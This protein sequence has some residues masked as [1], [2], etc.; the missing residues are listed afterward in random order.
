MPA[1]RLG[2]CYRSNS[3]SGRPWD[4]GRPG[5]ARLPS[6]QSR[7]RPRDGDGKAGVAGDAH[8]LLDVGRLGAMS[9]RVPSGRKRIGGFTDKLLQRPLL[10]LEIVLVQDFLR[11]AWSKRAWASSVST[12][13]DVPT[14]KL[15]FACANCSEMEFSALPRARRCPAPGG[16]RNRPARRAGSGPASRWR[17]WP[18]S[19]AA[20][21][22]P[23]RWRSSSASGRSAATGSRVGLVVVVDVLEVVAAV[24]PVAV[25]GRGGGNGGQ[26]AARAC[27][28]FSSP[29][30]YWAR[31][32]WK[33][34]SLTRASR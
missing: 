24:E 32:D 28:I 25:G 21:A 4:S 12:M 6:S 18:P 3:P 11:H 34:G 27:G 15:R 30:W 5:P 17:R 1:V 7:H 2:S 31:D 19:A 33:T 9:G 23:A 14:S 13:V 26:V 20:A 22:P 16:R 8:P 10:H 29:A